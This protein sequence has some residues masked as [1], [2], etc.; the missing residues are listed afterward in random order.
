MPFDKKI[1]NHATNG[2]V[3]HK[4]DLTAGILKEKIKD[5]DP[6]LGDMAEVKGWAL[7]IGRE[8]LFTQVSASF[9]RKI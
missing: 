8:N 4:K 1:R 3:S 5:A 9:M 7:S 6:Y 2:M